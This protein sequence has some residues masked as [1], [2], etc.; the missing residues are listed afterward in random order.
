M[1]M[2]EWIVLGH[3]I[4]S[5]GIKVD[6]TKIEVILKISIL[7]TQKEVLSFLGQQGTIGGL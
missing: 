1:M 5:D 6:L 2:N 3:L 4:S 7:K